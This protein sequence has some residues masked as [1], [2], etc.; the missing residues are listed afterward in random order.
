MKVREAVQRIATGI[1]ATVLAVGGVVALGAQPASAAYVCANNQ[2]C[3]YEG[4]N[5]SGTAF[6]PQE[7]SNSSNSVPDF[8]YRVFTNGTNAND[9]VSSIVNNTGWSLAVYRDV[10]FGGDHLIVPPYTRTNLSWPYDNEISSA[11]FAT[12][13]PIGSSPA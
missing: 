1:L 2:V 10:W 3:F 6:V 12:G 13:V 4:A 11:K 8:R 5:Y 7:L 9:R